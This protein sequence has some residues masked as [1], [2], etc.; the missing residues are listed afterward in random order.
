M[1]RSHTHMWATLM[2]YVYRGQQHIILFF[3]ASN[4]RKIAQPLTYNMVNAQKTI[5]QDSK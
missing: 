2:R 4:V 1:E 3:A 5:M